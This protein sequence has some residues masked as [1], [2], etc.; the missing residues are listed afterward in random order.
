MK[1]IVTHPSKTLLLKNVLKVTCHM[2]RE[3]FNLNAALERMNTY[4]RTKGAAQVGPMIQYLCPGM[5]AAGQMQMELTILIQCDRFLSDAPQPYSAAK[6][7]RV[8]DCMYCR[9]MGPQDKLKFAYDKLT[10]EAFEADIPLRGDSYTVFVSENSDEQT[11]V[12]DV[13]MPREEV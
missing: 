4:L 6:I 7:L 3:D 10:I 12:A 1:K 8:P 11:L 9:Y 5:D 2:E 13:F